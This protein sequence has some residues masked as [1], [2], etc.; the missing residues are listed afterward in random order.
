MKP[1]KNRVYCKDS[2]RHKMLFENEKKANLFIKFNSEEIE[3]EAGYSPNRSYYC[4]FCN[5]WH[6]T[7]S[8]EHIN[9]KSKTEIVLDLYKHDKEKKAKIAEIKKNKTESLNK[10]LQNVERQIEILDTIKGYGNPNRLKEILGIAF[11]ELDI[12]KSL[13]WQDPSKFKI[14]IIIY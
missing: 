13:R 3:S 7:S 2:G 11:R 1:T 6:V 14:E 10:H 8:K 4:M 5:G 12:A 9:V